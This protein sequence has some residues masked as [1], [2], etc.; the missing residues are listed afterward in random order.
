[1]YLLLHKC[2]QSVGPQHRPSLEDIRP[3]HDGAFCP[4]ANACTGKVASKA[5]R[6]IPRFIFGFL[7]ISNAAHS[8][9]TGRCRTQGGRCGL[10]AWVIATRHHFRG[11]AREPAAV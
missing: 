3:Y 10:A 8:A 1:M 5:A 11:A 9:E 2:P 7:P 4:S 6:I